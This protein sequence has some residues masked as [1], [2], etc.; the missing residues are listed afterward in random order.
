MIGGQATRTCTSLAPPRSRRCCRSDLSVVLRTMVSSTSSTRLPPS[1]SRSGLYFTRARPARFRPP[2]N[3][4]P[5]RRGEAHAAPTV[6]LDDD[7]LARLQRVDVT[8]AE[9]LQGHALAGGSEQWAVLGVA[10]RPQAE[11]VAQDHHV[12]DRVQ[13]DDVVR[14]VELLA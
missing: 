6:V 13:K 11:R 10:Q 1:T 2:M 4:R 3:A 7:H 9:V 14:P 5:R 8:E 12:A